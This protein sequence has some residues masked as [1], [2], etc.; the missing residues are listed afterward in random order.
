M[1]ATTTDDRKLASLDALVDERGDRWIEELREF[2]RIPCETG[3]LDELA[4]GARWT[5]DRLRAAGCE[6]E[7]IEKDGAPPLVV[8]E[9]GSGDTTL[10]CVQ[11]YDVQP[12]DPIALWTTPPYDP[13]VR[14]GH[15][16]ARGVSDNKGHLLMRIQVVEAYREAIGELPCRVRFL[17][18]G[19]EESSSAWF[20]EALRERPEL[21]RGDGALGEGGIID[22]RDRPQLGCGVRGILYVELGVQTLKYDAHSG[23]ASLYEN[24]AWRLVEALATLRQPDGTVTIDGFHDDVLD[25][26]AEQLDALRK[27]PFEEA[28]LKDI[29]GARR[30]V[31]DVTGFDAQVAQLFRPTC[32]IAG[33]SSGWTGPGAK[34]ITPAE[35]RVKI[36]MRLVPN[37]DP[38]R[39]EAAL[40]AHLDARGFGDVS[41]TRLGSDHPHWTPVSDPLVDAADRAV[42][43]VFGSPGLRVLSSAGT[44]P[45][46]QVCAPFGIPM[47]S[48][49]FSHPKSRVHAPDENV[50]LDL[51]FKA[52]KATGR[53]LEEFAAR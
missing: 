47:V 30:F 21:V 16:Y 29:Y 31:G 4:R 42:A 46:H 12:A 27:V 43:Q 22:A 1:S 34:T 15:L 3:H 8:G 36:D 48:F 37:Q 20:T 7:T 49:G 38:E 50:R 5:A 41:I 32:N 35:A 39:I 45:M 18:E 25:P 26:T 44:A 2:C 9:I 19:Q 6:V 53:F 51:Y 24:A 52:A 10:I 14:D 23:G 13:D 17:A 28:E 33:I 11:H 40:R